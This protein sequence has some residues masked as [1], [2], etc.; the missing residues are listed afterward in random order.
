[1]S[2]P[3][4]RRKINRLA[5]LASLLFGIMVC[6]AAEGPRRGAAGTAIAP[7]E[8]TSSPAASKP[9]AASPAERLREGTRLVDC[10]G[11]FQFA[12]EGDRVAFFPSD[13]KESYRVLENLALERVSGK[14]AESRGKPE[15]IVSG[16]LTEFRGSNYLLM[17]KVLIRSAAERPAA[18]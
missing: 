16:T 8:F 14:L 12:G 7:G 15:W 6:T 4:L 9:A 11:R 10:A 17:T 2:A 1:M 13:S 3:L 18:P 5:L